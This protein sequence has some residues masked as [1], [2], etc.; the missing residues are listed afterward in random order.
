MNKSV[1]VNFNLL[2]GSLGFNTLNQKKGLQAGNTSLYKNLV[3][4]IFLASRPFNYLGL[5]HTECALLSSYEGPPF[6]ELRLL[7]SKHPK[8]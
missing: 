3:E 2:T 4:G 7:F 8:H 1:N 6:Q 5:H